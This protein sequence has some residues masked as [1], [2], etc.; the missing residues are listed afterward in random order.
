MSPKR[1]P[2]ATYGYD[3]KAFRII[4]VRKVSEL[5]THSFTHEIEKIRNFVNSRLVYL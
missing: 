1:V 2:K 4:R 3:L 5:L